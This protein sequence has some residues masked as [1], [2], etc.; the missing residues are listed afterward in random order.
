VA[1][2]RTNG[3]YMKVAIFGG[4]G[5]LGGY[6]VDE[7]LRQTHEPVLLVRP[8]SESKLRQPERCVTV[9]GDVTDP[10]SVR[11]T[12]EGC[13]AAIYAIGI[14]REF[15][16]KGITFEQL[17]F[18][19]AR[20]AI[21][22][23]DELGVRRFLLVSANGARENGTPYQ[24]TK[25]QAEQHLRSSTLDYT[26]L[27]PSILFGDPRG[28]M[29]FCTRLRDQM[30]RLP[31]PAPLFYEGLLPLN[32][33]GFALSPIHV[34]DV[35]RIMIQSLAM[36]AAVGQTF[37]LCG[38]QAIEWRAII[39]LIA[40]ACGTSKLTVPVP[41]FYIK[42]LATL[43]ESY[44]FFPITRDQLTMLLEGNTGDSSAVYKRFD[45]D[46]IRFTEAA[47]SY[48]QGSRTAA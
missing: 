27:R 23:A 45:V 8:G 14:L 40:R 34:T 37:T 1:D 47:L 26:I 10:G 48:L 36:P 18:H 44:E 11:R 20:R 17:Q 43:L 29:E 31:L 41:A 6:L 42:T 24:R 3:K 38:P 4:T 28:R 9:G 2:T 25:F 13:E 19:G 12:L 39:H 15:P 30:I 16:R 5:F 32:A 46:P 33:G 22:A 7:L 21:D 35:A